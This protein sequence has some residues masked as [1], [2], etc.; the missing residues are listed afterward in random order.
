MAKKSIPGSTN[1]H[2]TRPVRR[3]PKTPPRGPAAVKAAERLALRIWVEIMIQFGRG[4]EAAKAVAEADPG[5][6]FTVDQVFEKADDYNI[7]KKDEDFRS[8]VEPMLASNRRAARKGTTS[9]LQYSEDRNAVRRNAF[10]YGAKAF[11]RAGSG[12]QVTSAHL[13]AALDWVR[14]EYCDDVAVGAGPY[15]A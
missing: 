10:M 9:E 13:A 4:F 6:R 8:L 1:V 15:C 7:F 5:R 2:A 11:E 3:R 14:R 12:R